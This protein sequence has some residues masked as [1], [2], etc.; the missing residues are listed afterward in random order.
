MSVETQDA[1]LLQVLERL[2]AALRTLIHRLS[3]G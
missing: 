3:L 2:F 1:R